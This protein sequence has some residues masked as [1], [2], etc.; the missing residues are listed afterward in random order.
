MSSQV[1]TSSCVFER[2]SMCQFPWKDRDSFLTDPGIKLVG[3]QVNF[4]DLETGLF[5]FNHS[6]GTTLGIEAERF[7][8]LYDGPIF[9]EPATGTDACPG[10][11]LRG[12]ELL[13]CPAECECAYVR[14]VLHIINGWP[15]N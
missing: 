9:F 6:C 8:D 4:L 1:A 2:C 12:K 10:H 13:P 15:K 3:Y 7:Q 14:E 11:C 5:L